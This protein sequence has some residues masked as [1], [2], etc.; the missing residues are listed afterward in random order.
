MIPA[1]TPARWKGRT[2]S[3]LELLGLALCDAFRIPLTAI[4]VD[5]RVF[6]LLVEMRLMLGSR[7]KSSDGGAAGYFNG[8]LLLACGMAALMGAVYGLFTLTANSPGIVGFV[9]SLLMTFYGATLTIT[10]FADLLFDGATASFFAGRPVDDKTAFAARVAPASISVVLVQASLAIPMI[11]IAMLR[12]DGFSTGAALAATAA[13]NTVLATAIVLVAFAMVLRF[14]TAERFKSI[15]VKAQLVFTLVMMLAP[16][17]LRFVAPKRGEDSVFEFDGAWRLLPATWYREFTE[18]IAGGGAPYGPTIPLLAI[19]APFLLLAISFALVRGKFVVALSGGGAEK[20][21]TCRARSLLDAFADRLARTTGERAGYGLATALQLRERG[22]ML[23]SIPQVV[24]SLVIPL[25]FIGPTDETFVERI[26][27]FAHGLPLGAIMVVAQLSRTD[28]PDAAW[29]FRM[30]PRMD[31]GPVRAGAVRATLIRFVGLPI[32][33]FTILATILGGATGAMNALVAGAIAWFLA[34][35]GA[36]VVASGVPFSTKF[37][38]KTAG[39]AAGLYFCFVFLTLGATAAQRFLLDR[40]EYAIPVFV[41]FAFLGAVQ[42]ASFR[43]ART[44]GK[45]AN[46]A[47]PLEDGAAP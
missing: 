34:G 35:S 40:W 39:G 29:V 25:A 24:Y 20:E 47:L 46:V 4:G 11:A 6:R 10:I 7:R 14:S 23:Q 31:L 19:A 38:K 30:S 33:T 44:R 28:D 8:G 18:M 45:S 1:A 32:V 12:F 2:H 5:F 3:T 42:F 26:G 9:M 37:D 22:A 43:G 15:V 17:L 16:Q 41:L 21:T 36:R 27:L 13:L